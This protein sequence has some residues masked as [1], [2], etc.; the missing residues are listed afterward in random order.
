MGQEP[1]AHLSAFPRGKAG[2][3]PPAGG[4]QATGATSSLGFDFPSVS[5]PI[6][7]KLMEL[8]SLAINILIGAFLIN[9]F[10]P[11]KGK[12]NPLYSS[13]AWLIV[14]KRENSSFLF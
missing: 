2:S 14:F 7:K 11:G 9:I 10:T 12:A 6:S 13:D 5:P 4:V 8:D 1:S 3:L